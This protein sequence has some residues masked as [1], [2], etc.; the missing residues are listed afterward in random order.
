MQ[1]ATV[2]RSP[3]IL[4]ELHWA[5]NSGVPIKC[6][7]LTGSGYVLDKAPYFLASIEKQLAPG[8]VEQMAKWLLD[9][10]QAT[11]SKMKWALHREIPAIIAKV[12]EPTGSSHQR[13]A[14]VCDLVDDLL[15]LY[16]SSSSTL[17]DEVTGRLSGID[18]GR[19]SRKSNGKVKKW[20]KLSI[21]RK[22]GQS[23]S[24]RGV[25]FILSTVPYDTQ[26]VGVDNRSGMH[27][28]IRYT[29]TDTQCC[30]I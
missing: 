10:K 21:R 2:L 19:L 3:T 9:N 11:L 1:S 29:H 20:T 18:E 8:V 15:Q 14:I 7:G 25:D 22:I 27:I 30:A 5:L 24:H 26:V 6:V 28:L 4:L 16:G 13:H 12:Y 17:H 23:W